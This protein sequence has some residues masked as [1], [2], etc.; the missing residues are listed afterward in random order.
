MKYREIMLKFEKENS[1]HND[2]SSHFHFEN[3]INNP[4][5]TCWIIRIQRIVLLSDSKCTC[6]DFHVQKLRIR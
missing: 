4:I 6:N 3:K 2:N 1:V 5:Y